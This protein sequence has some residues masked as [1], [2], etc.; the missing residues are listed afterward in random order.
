[1]RLLTPRGMGG[2]AVIAGSGPAERARLLAL[3][4][5][6][7]LRP[8][9]T[10][11]GDPPR[12]AVLLLDGIV[13]DEVLVVDRADSV[14]EVH[15]HGSPAVVEM[16]EARLS[17]FTEGPLQPAE[18]LL[19]EALSPPQLELALEQLESDF[20]RGIAGLAA[21][22][23]EARRT[24]GAAALLRSRTA[25]ALAIPQRV[26]IV[27]RQNA[28]KSTLFNR[29]L[30][31]ER[32]LAGSEPGLTRDVVID[33]TT[34]RGYPYELVDTPGEGEVAGIDAAALDRGRAAARDALLLLVVDG[35]VGPTAADIGRL[36][37]R[38]LVIA[39]KADLPTA[40]WPDAVP[41]HLRSSA[42]DAGTAPLLRQQVGDL[43]LRCRGLGSAGAVGGFAALDES[44]WRRLLEVVGSDL[45]RDPPA[46]VVRPGQPGQ[47]GQPGHLGQLGD[48][49][50]DRP[51]GRA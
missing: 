26:C 17:P 14:L 50:G 39:N 5:S 24:A 9:S 48:A 29:L 15:L 10:R 3:L 37:E 18:R 21:M 22:G 34:L 8:L 42:R 1:M 2:I 12:L 51:P 23:P 35:S 28:G 27:G 47:P 49:A 11:P 46:E 19:R 44:Q 4:A 25:L 40:P 31:R 16:L 30:L 41:C 7:S 33:R 36:G 20:D 45:D 43:L 32:A 13:R 6:P 38:T